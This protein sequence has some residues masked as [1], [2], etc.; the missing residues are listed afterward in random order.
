MKADISSAMRLF[1]SACNYVQ[2]AGLA[3]EVAWQR[4]AE[5]SEFT[6]TDLLREHAWVTLCS[7]FRESVVRKVFDHVSLCFCDWESS[8]AIVTSGEV[9]CITA[10]SCFSNHAKLRGILTSAIQVHGAGFGKFKSSVLANPIEQLQSL[11]FMGPVTSWHLAKNLGLDVAKPDRHL[12]RV[13]RILGFRDAN[14]LCQEISASTGE[15]TKVVDLIVWR[16]IADNPGHLRT[17]FA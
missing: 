8:E 2:S 3:A 10:A 5:F 15:Q 13:S 4:N 16:Y 1:S 6:E 14:H 7:G 12:I 17:S 9:C 11:P